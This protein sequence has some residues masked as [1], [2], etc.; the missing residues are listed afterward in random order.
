[1]LSKRTIMIFGITLALTFI[2]GSVVLKGIP[3]TF[4]G[5]LK[6]A[7]DD[8]GNQF[9]PRNAVNH[10]F[11][12][13]M[14]NVTPYYLNNNYG[15]PMMAGSGG[16]QAQGFESNAS[17]RVPPYRM[18]PYS[19]SKVPLNYEHKVIKNAEVSLIVPDAGKTQTILGDLITRF[20][21]VMMS[22]QMSKSP[23]GST[24]GTVVFKVLPKD[25]GNVL[26]QVRKL[27]DVQWENQSGEDVTEQY[28]DTQARLGNYKVVRDRLHKTLEENAHRVDDILEVEREIARV[29]G[30]IEALEGRMKFLETQSDM[31]TV[32]VSFM[33]K[34]KHALQGVDS[35]NK[36]TST[37][38]QSYETFI[39]T[40]NGIIVIL[41]FLLPIAIWL[42]LF[43]GIYVFISKIFKK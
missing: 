2:I 17:Y 33:E 34:T 15:S 1:M 23:D 12:K 43:W 10:M 31:A 22:S 20:N 27:G 26:A 4:P 5:R 41:A 40:F 19:Y 3:R 35:E 28:I 42:L 8:I 25:L 6:S 11:A 39:N 37:V 36:W 21:G 29:E 24:N 9:S 13:K 7:S 38:K 32:T 18:P 14:P 30:E 16:L